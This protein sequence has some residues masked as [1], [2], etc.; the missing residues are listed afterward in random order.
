MGCSC[1]WLG[2]AVANAICECFEPFLLIA[3]KPHTTTPFCADGLAEQSR[4]NK[5]SSG[6]PS[7]WDI[8]PKAPM[9]SVASFQLS[10]CAPDCPM[11]EDSLKM[12]Q[13]FKARM[14]LFLALFL[15]E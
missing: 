6:H 4:S 3:G 15:L 8:T 12:S 13:L 9:T 14:H 2:S 5:L 7:Y 11:K 1:G 10:Q